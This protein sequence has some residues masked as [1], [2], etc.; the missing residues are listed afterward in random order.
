MRFTHNLAEIDRDDLAAVREAVDG[1][2]EIGH[3]RR[4][5]AIYADHLSACAEVVT[6]GGK[7]CDCGFSSVL[8]PPKDGGRV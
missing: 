5:F 4:I 8:Q 7:D 1:A 2:Q 3:W 6:I